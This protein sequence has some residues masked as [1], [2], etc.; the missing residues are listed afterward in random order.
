MTELLRAL[1]F[2]VWGAIHVG[3]LPADAEPIA[4]ALVSATLQRAQVE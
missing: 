1:V 4:D 3:P 2:S